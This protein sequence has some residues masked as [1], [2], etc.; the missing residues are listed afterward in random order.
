MDGPSVIYD[1]DVDVLYFS[2]CRVPVSTAIEDPEGIVWRYDR[3][4]NLIGVTVMDYRAR[5]AG[6]E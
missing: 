4:G 1:S 3:C 2:A 5:R 6:L